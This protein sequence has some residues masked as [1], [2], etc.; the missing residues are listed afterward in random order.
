MM[1]GKALEEVVELLKADGVKLEEVEWDA[2]HSPLADLLALP[3]EHEERQWAELH[4]GGYWADEHLVIGFAH[5]LVDEVYY[6][7]DWD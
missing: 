6:S 4:L 7:E 2:E 1:M 5:G 3:V